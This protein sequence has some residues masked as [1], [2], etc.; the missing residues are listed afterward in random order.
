MAITSMKPVK[1]RDKKQVYDGRMTERPEP[2]GYTAAEA[3]GIFGARPK[4]QKTYSRHEVEQMRRDVERRRHTTVV[5]KK[6]KRPTV[7]ETRKPGEK[8][9]RE[10]PH[11]FTEEEADRVEA[12]NERK[13]A[14]ELKRAKAIHARVKEDMA[15]RQRKAWEK[16]DS[17]LSC[18]G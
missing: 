6:W 10:L 16:L 1:A 14:N 5:I 15:E 17:M 8:G 11:D 13:A 2:C 9:L 18:T 3:R 12:Y 7:A 4:G